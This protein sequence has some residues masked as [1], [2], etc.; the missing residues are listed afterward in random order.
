[1]LFYE[2]RIIPLVHWLNKVEDYKKSRKLRSAKAD[3]P[4][5]YDE[6]LTNIEDDGTYLTYNF[7][8]SQS[9]HVDVYDGYDLKASSSIDIGLRVYP[10]YKQSCHGD[11][12]GDYYVVT[13][14]ITP[15]NQ[16]MWCPYSD[17]CG[18]FDWDTFHM[19][20]YWFNHMQTAIK[21]VDKDGNEPSGLVYDTTP[22]PEN[23]INSHQYTQGTS[24]TIGGSVN[25]GFIAGDPTVTAGLSFSHTVSSTVS[26]SMDDI[27]Y[28]LNSATREVCYDYDSKN[29][30]PRDDTDYDTYWPKNCRTHWTVRQAWVWFVPRGESGVDDNSDVAFQ[31]LINGKLKISSYWYAWHWS[32]DIG[33]E[34]DDFTPLTIENQA[35]QLKAPNRY[36]WGLSSIKSEYTD[37]VMANIRYYKTG[38]EEKDPVAVDELSYHQGDY[39]LMGLPEASYTIIYET[40]DPNT[41]AHMNS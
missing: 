7:P 37:A 13:T 12:S 23:A 25:G 6:L 41:G 16:N 32:G 21:L 14:E 36:S 27:E 9:T 35:W 31:I 39:A 22:I 24:T 26:Y 4:Y 5:N 11:K 34:Q 10:L 28:T 2:R 40:K 18:T 29:V 1:M 38:D 8:Y 3:E 33:G 19:I 20:G 15:Y 17:D 30:N